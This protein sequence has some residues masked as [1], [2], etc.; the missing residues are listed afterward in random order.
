MN[1]PLDFA[2]GNI[3]QYLLRLRWILLKYYSQ[4]TI[5]WCSGRCWVVLN[6]IGFFWES[7]CVTSDV[8]F[9]VCTLDLGFILTN[10]FF[11]ILFQAELVA[12]RHDLVEE[13]AA[14]QVLEK[15]VNNLLLQLHAVQLQLH[16]NSGM[17]NDSENIK[18]KLVS[19]T[20]FLR[21]HSFSWLWSRETKA[22]KSIC[23]PRLQSWTEVLRQLILPKLTLSN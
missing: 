22:G 12:L 16:S 20:L 6:W 17:P 4:H 13:R 21:I 10:I 8:I 3:H 23:S 9:I 11:S 19:K 18:N 7:T 1:I 5:C 2:S 15:E 14:K